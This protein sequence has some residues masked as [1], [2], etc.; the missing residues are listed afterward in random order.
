MDFH[1]HFFSITNTTTTPTTITTYPAFSLTFCSPRNASHIHVKSQLVVAITN[2][3]ICGRN[4]ARRR[5]RDAPNLP[6]ARLQVV[7]T[8]L[9]TLVFVVFLFLRN[10]ITSTYD[11]NHYLES[12]VSLIDRGSSSLHAINDGLSD[13]DLDCY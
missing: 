8:N 1:R 4:S 13:P 10:N 2:R 5:R 9:P 7:G 11:L 12:C 6:V 3:V